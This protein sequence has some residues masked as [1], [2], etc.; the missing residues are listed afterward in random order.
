MQ[1]FQ[2]KNPKIS[3]KFLHFLKKFEDSDNSKISEKV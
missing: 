1:K 3:E 2:K